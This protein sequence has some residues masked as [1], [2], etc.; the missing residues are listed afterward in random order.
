MTSLAGTSAPRLALPRLTRRAFTDLGLWM[1]A[2]GLGL[3]VLFP[4][5]LIPLGVPSA[6][7]LRPAFFAVSIGAG[8]LL[9]AV[10]YAL[11][12]RVI[13][14]RVVQVSRQMRQV[15][16]S[17]AEASHS[18]DWDACTPASCQLPVDSDDE[19]GE[20]AESFNDLVAALST[21]HEMH[22][23]MAQ[24]NRVLS[25]H[26]DLTEFGRTTLRNFLTSAQAQAGAFCVVRDG[27][28]DVLADVRLQIAGLCEHPAVLAALT[29]AAP[30][31]IELPPG[32]VVEAVAVAFRPAAVALLP[33]QFRKIP[34]GVIVLAFSAPP[35]EDTMRLLDKFCLPAGVAL[36]NSL[37]HE[38][39]QQL[40]AVDSLTGAYNRR[41]GLG[42]LDEE[43]AR[44]IRSGT[45]LGVLTFDLDHFKTVNDTYGH[46][47]GDRVLRDTTA[48]ARLAL[49]E[50]DV[51]VRT[52]GEEFVVVLPGA[53]L[54]D[55]R[56]VG[57]RIR[58]NVANLT[59]PVGQG[60]VQI[61]VSLGATT[62]ADCAAVSAQELLAAVDEAMYT[63]KRQGRN[64]LTMAGHA[65]GSLM[66]V[67]AASGAPKERS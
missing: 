48:A 7:T 57:E 41:F 50:G 52:G 39:F 34:L 28:L 31:Q 42:R 30:V 29:E 55:V 43:W 32:L 12:R 20:V 63:S 66:P 60:N 4:F 23:A 17:I 18:E 2:L 8:L 22:R 36:N 46:L 35:S 67:V 33:I 59:I 54:E 64:R 62:V 3:G 13:G 51:L 1:Q 16:S 58:N 10:N 27:H 9:G 56:A 47:A 49:R 38:R 15:G 11:A 61:T 45:P 25:E 37:T 19:L 6:H 26:L 24:T 5:A 44:S 14:I 40:A 65:T 21:S 53:G